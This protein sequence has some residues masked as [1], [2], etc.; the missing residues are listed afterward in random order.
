[1]LPLFAG[2]TDFKPG[3]WV[4]LKY[5]EPL[6]KNDGRSVHAQVIYRDGTIS[7]SHD[8]IFI[9][10]FKKNWRIGEKKELSNELKI[11]SSNPCFLTKKT[12]VSE[13]TYLNFILI[14]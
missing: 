10:I 6:G 1:M 4:G 5:D 11:K 13:L 12:Q 8:T 3:Y 2:T 7:K 9:T 14:F